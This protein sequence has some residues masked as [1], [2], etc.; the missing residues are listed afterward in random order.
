MERSHS[1]QGI[2]L[3]SMAALVN[4]CLAQDKNPFNKLSD[5]EIQFVLG[6]CVRIAKTDPCALL[7]QRP[8]NRNSPTVD[9]EPNDVVNVACQAILGLTGN[10]WKET[11]HCLEASKG[12]GSGVKQAPN[13]PLPP[14]PPARPQAQCPYVVPQHRDA[15]LV[16]KKTDYLELCFWVPVPHPNPDWSFASKDM[17]KAGVCNTLLNTLNKEP[18]KEKEQC[19]SSPTCQRDWAALSV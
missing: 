17:L 11:N 7:N 16:Q 3:S 2:A 4:D 19:N 5:T 10:V 1:R 12:G 8:T 6:K 9:L 13:P 18:N 15:P 14:R